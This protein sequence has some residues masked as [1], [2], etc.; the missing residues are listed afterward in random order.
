LLD[1]EGRKLRMP[2]LVALEIVENPG[3]SDSIA[4]DPSKGDGWKSSGRR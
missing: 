2:G 4:N 3:R 1:E